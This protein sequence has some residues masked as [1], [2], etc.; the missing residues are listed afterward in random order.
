VG[1]Q[2]EVVYLPQVELTHFGRVSTRQHIGFASTN[3][4]I[5]FARY[6]RKSGCSRL[7]LVAYK[8]LVTLDAPL[9]FAAKGLEYLGRRLAGRRGKAEKSLLALRGVGH[10][11]VK[12]LLP[13]WR[14]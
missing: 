4:A 5:G 9:L 6:L 12:G 7:A 1:Q 8:L 13:F 14:V 11:L 3:M 10:F 2:A